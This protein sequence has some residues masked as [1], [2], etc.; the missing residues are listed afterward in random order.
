MDGWGRVRSSLPV[1][2]LL[3]VHTV[4]SLQNVV[5]PYEEPSAAEKVRLRSVSLAHPVL[6]A[7]SQ[8]HWHGRKLQQTGRRW[9]S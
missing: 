3:C 8:L 6:V 2:G 5:H 7:P 9:M 4:A 1:C